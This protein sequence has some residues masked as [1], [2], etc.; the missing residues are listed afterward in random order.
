MIKKILKENLSKNSLGVNIS[1]PQVLILMRGCPGSGK[2]TQAKKLAMGGAVH[3]TD[4]VIESKGDY[5]AFFEEMKKK[6]NFSA[7]S[8]MHSLNLQNAKKSMADGVTPVVIDNTNLRPAE[9]KQYVMAAL[10][11]GYSD[12]NIKIVNVGIGGV[13]AEELAARN[14]HGVPLDKIEQ[15]IKTYNGVGKVTL[16]NILASK[17]M[18]VSSDVLYSAIVLDDISHGM[19]LR[20]FA[21]KIPDGW[22]TY[23]HHMTIAMG[24]GAKDEDLGK[25]VSLTVTALGESDMAVAVMVHGYSSTNAIPHVTLAVNPNGG[26]PVMSNQIT[27]W[28]EV[29]E[30]KIR[31]VITNYMKTL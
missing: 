12:N 16:E 27:S 6:N 4:D 21:N 5:R 2:S 28:K 23:A 26:K 29:E 9:M 31:G 10:Q 15:M 24:V 14:T 11:L 3:S 17:D 7:L 1:T 13:T 8:R 30:L 25:E 18:P 19:L 20:E 22:K